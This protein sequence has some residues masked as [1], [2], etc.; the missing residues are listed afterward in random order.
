[1]RYLMLVLALV[2]PIITFGQ[3]N[4]S[5]NVIKPAALTP[6]MGEVHHPVSTG[7]DEAQQFFNQG[8][9]YI[10]GFNHEEAVRSF[11][12]AAELDPQLAMAQ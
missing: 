9:A 2:V 6:G 5:A 7:N 4:H 11:R 12:R 8:L 3:H 10:Y 1:M